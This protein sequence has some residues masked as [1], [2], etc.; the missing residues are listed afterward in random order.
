MF[1]ATINVF[2][3]DKM[4]NMQPSIMITHENFLICSSLQLLS[5]FLYTFSSSSDNPSVHPLCQLI[6]S[7]V[8]TCGS[9][10]AEDAIKFTR[11]TMET[12]PLSEQVRCHAISSVGVIY[13]V[14]CQAHPALVKIGPMLAPSFSF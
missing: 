7:M 9:S 1:G 8:Q 13:I 2:E 12:N 11:D 4:Q 3:F 6:S 5:S 10:S 14:A